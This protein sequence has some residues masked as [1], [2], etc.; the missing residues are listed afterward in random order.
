MTENNTPQIFEN[1]S[2]WIRADFHLHT[3]EDKE[4]VYAGNEND[5]VNQY[6][7]KLKAEGIRVAIITNHNKFAVSE[8]K[9]IAKKARKE[10]IYVLPGVELSVNDG[11]NGIHT[12]VVFDPEQWLENGNDLINHF[13]TST[14]SGKVNFENE[15]GRSN[16]SL[17]QTIELLNSFQKNYFLLMAHVEQRS[18]FMEELDGGR[19]TEFASNP[20]FRKSVLGFQ[21]VRTRD[22]VANLNVWFKNQLPAFIE[23][24]DPKSLEEMVKE[25]SVI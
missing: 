15:N 2:T 23:G 3:K 10:E 13:L 24:S 8:Y 21:K 20:L 7:E 17:K 22:K 5:F 16:H 14:F 9:A 4:F 25:K 12:L 1:G 11:S 18:G 6:V 19:I